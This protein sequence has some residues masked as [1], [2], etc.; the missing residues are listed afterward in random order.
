ML[1]DNDI[2][3]CGEIGEFGEIYRQFYHRPKEAIKHLRKMQ[4]GECPGALYRDDIGNID[5]IWGEVTD[6]IKHKGYGLAHIID[7]HESDIKALGFE[8]EDFIPIV[9]QFGNLKPTSSGEEY[10]LESEMFRVVIERYWRNIPKQW[11]LT[12]FDLRKKSRRK[13]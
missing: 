7:K 4:D 8:V 6:P 13:P 12:T 9:V 1:Y 10:L 2:Y 5:I 3:G 11:I